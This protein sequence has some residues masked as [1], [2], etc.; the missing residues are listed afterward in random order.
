[1]GECR[2]TRWPSVN[3]WIIAI[4]VGV[5][6]GCAGGTTIPGA[7]TE[8]AANGYS[9]TLISAE[10]ASGQKLV[11]GNEVTFNI[12]VSY[13]NSISR[14]AEVMLVFQDENN[15]NL[16]PGGKQVRAEAAGKAGTV[17]LQ[18]SLTIPATGHELRL[19]VPLVPYGVAN[20]SGGIALRY[21]LVAAQ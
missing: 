21:P 16:D 3:R 1:V 7:A 18:R 2:T 6:A 13:K 9:I 11:R 15:E 5:V 10:P 8:G 19:F 14:R 20:T 12:S 4:A 17:S